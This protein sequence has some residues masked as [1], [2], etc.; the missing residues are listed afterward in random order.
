[1]Q[2]KKYTKLRILIF[3]VFVAIAITFIAQI[4]TIVGDGITIINS[5][6]SEIRCT[7]L[8]FTVTDIT[9]TNNNLLFRLSSK[10]YATEITQV[11]V[12][13]RDVEITHELA[14]PIGGGQDKFIKTN[15]ISIEN[16][17]EVFVNECELSKKGLSILK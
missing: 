8:S 15:N 10:D 11:T 13:S 4:I 5:K 7:D 14:S 6:N 12:L 16:T 1:M 3:F 2:E 17:F 9:Y